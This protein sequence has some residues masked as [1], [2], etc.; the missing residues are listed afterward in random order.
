MRILLA[1][2]CLVLSLFV[3]LRSSEWA[4]LTECES[5]L[6]FREN[7][8]SLMQNFSHVLATVQVTLIV[9]GHLQCYWASKL[10]RISGQGSAHAFSASLSSLEG[11][12]ACDLINASKYYT[13]AKVRVRE[14][15]TNFIYDSDWGLSDPFFTSM[16]IQAGLPTV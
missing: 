12:G 8:S 11:K 15:C 10:H 14:R 1:R 3:V 5:Q 13:Q 6:Q 2:L 9:S 4:D 7:V 16:P